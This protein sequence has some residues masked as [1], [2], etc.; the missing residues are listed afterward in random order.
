MA[1]PL[2]ARDCAAEARAHGWGALGQ[3]WGRAAPHQGESHPQ[4]PRGVLTAE[5]VA[6]KREAKAVAAAADDGS[7]AEMVAEV[8]AERGGG[9][10]PAPEVKPEPEAPLPLAPVASLAPAPA[11]EDDSPVSDADIPETFGLNEEEEDIWEDAV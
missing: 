11:A 6:A 2:P 3:T 4:Q 5:K 1:R 10:A 7:D 8:V 9:V